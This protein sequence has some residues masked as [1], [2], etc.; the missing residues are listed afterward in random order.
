MKR[1]AI[2]AALLAAAFAIAAEGQEIQRAELLWFGNYTATE[3][4]TIEDPA[5]PTGRRL[6]SKGVKGPA[7]NSDRIAI[8][9]G[10]TRF[11]FGYRLVGAQNGK[12]AKVIHIFRFP[13]NGIPGSGGAL[14]QST[15]VVGEDEIGSVGHIGWRMDGNEPK[16]YEG[17]WTL[18]IW[19]EER[20]LLERKFT[21][22]RP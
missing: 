2:L 9:R 5:S 13:G 15:T 11:G 12:S 6:I 21:L 18:Q 20:L 22:Y 16:E 4:Q 3:V 17:V 19:S 14:Q 1:V 8:V 10:D 7:T